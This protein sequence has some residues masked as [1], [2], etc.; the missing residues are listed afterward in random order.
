M[1]WHIV[2]TRSQ[3]SGTGRKF[4]PQKGSGRARHGD[5]NAPMF[6]G[7]GKAHG[8]RPKDYTTKLNKKIR[9][10]GLKTALSTRYREGDFYLFDDFRFTDGAF[11]S[12]EKFMDR[13]GWHNCLCVYM[14]DLNKR[15]H[16]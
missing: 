12:A 10:L 14:G 15:F 2:R 11:E 9:W 4:R 1:S 3:I 13:W 5:R 6:V 7:G 16:R 8:R